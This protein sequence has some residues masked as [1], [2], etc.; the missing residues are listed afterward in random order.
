MMT[1]CTDIIMR[2]GHFTNDHSTPVLMCP[3]CAQGKPQEEPVID[4]PPE[5]IPETMEQ[6]LRDSQEVKNSVAGLT[7]GLK[8][9]LVALERHL[10]QL[11]KAAP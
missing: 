4:D 9:Q 1:E 8:L 5:D 6:L 11:R 10:E 2:Y 3:E 7:L